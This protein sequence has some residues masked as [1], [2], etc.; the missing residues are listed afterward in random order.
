MCSDMWQEF[1]T[2]RTTMAKHPRQ[3]MGPGTGSYESSVAASF[4]S[5]AAPVR[6]R[7]VQSGL[8][9][10]QSLLDS[11]FHRSEFGAR[12]S[13]DPAPTRS[14]AA[15]N[16]LSIRASTWGKSFYA[17]R[18]APPS[19]P[20]RATATYGSIRARP[21]RTRL[22]VGVRHPAWPPAPPRRRPHVRECRPS[23]MEWSCPG[24]EF[25]AAPPRRKKDRG[26]PS[27]PRKS[28]AGQMRLAHSTCPASWRNS[29]L[30]WR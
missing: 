4:R 18:C 11:S 16:P 22:R 21:S 6:S 20:S 13:L 26:P 5:G 24:L 7:F 28:R 23:H 2:G 12:P 19:T 15:F 10:L 17:S 27:S 14:S 25:S 1:R 3:G 30:A 9:L 29:Q 8:D